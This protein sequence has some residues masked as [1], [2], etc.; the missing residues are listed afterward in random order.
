MQTWMLKLVACGTT[1]SIQTCLLVTV[2]Q[3]LNAVAQTLRELDASH[4]LLPFS[5]ITTT[6]IRVLVTPNHSP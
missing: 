3:V 1:L 4:E 6:T 5:I 2:D